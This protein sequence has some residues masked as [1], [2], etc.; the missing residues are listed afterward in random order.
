MSLDSRTCAG[1]QVADLL[2]S[3]I[4]HYRQKV[5]TASL[6][7]FLQDGTPKARLTRGVAAVLE[8]GSFADCQTDL[9][10]IVTTHDKSLKELAVCR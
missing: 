9:M 1:L 8:V 4:F 7:Q 3:S 5:E 2:A 6:E 10:S